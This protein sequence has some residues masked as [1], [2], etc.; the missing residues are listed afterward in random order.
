MCND[1]RLVL[2]YFIHERY[3]LNL[4]S[5]SIRP[6]DQTL[7][8]EPVALV[9][10][11]NYQSVMFGLPNDE[12]FMGHPLAKRGL[13]PY[14][15]FRIAGS[16]WIRSLEQMNAVHP[17]HDASRFDEFTHYILA[18]HDSTFEC[19]AQAYTVTIVKGPRSKHISEMVHRLEL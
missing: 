14:G 18:F 15:V 1:F 8:E 6:T 5:E 10:F 11:T 16:S 12:A 2:T 17:K 19:V 4:D 13:H 9:E 3:R 7:I